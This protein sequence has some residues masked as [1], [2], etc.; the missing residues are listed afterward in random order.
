MHCVMEARY[1]AGTFPKECACGRIYTESMW[2]VLEFAY[3]QDSMLDGERYYDDLEA[4]H[5]TCGSTIAVAVR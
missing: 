1:K 5:C 4:R 3:F 2:E